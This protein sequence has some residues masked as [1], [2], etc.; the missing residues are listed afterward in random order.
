MPYIHVLFNQKIPPRDFN[1]T[2]RYKDPNALFRRVESFG[3]YS[4]NLEGDINDIDYD[5]VY[6]LDS[7]YNSVFLEAGFSIKEFENYSVAWLD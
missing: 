4:F 1:E 7:W 3:L 2:V 5:T 6:I